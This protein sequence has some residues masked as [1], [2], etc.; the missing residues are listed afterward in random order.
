MWRGEESVR[1]RNEITV[2]R[3]VK[4]VIG[5]RGCVLGPRARMERMDPAVP[6][7]PTSAMPIA[8]RRSRVDAWGIY[9]V[10]DTD[11]DAVL[12]VVCGEGV[13]VGGL[14]GLDGE[15]KNDV[16]RAIRNTPRRDRRDARRAVREKG[17]WRNRWQK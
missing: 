8:T 13:E 16:G 4:D 1:A 3:T 7:T 9:V 11:V 10:E 15:E 6:T 17:S 2:Q 14:D 12:F 5:R